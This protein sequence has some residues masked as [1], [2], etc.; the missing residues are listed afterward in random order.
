MNALRVYSCGRAIAAEAFVIDSNRVHLAQRQEAG[1][2]M[3]SMRISPQQDLWTG[4]VSC[5]RVKLARLRGRHWQKY[6]WQ[7]RVITPRETAGLHCSQ[8]DSG[9]EGHGG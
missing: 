7:E 8:T 4:S 3:P 5:A 1:K 2:Q 6:C 9:D